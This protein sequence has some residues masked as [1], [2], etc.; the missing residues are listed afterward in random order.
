[1]AVK[2]SAKLT[3]AR[4]ASIPLAYSIKTLLSSACWSC[5]ANIFCR[6]SCSASTCG[7]EM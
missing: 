3:P 1:M 2:A 4:S 7:P 5:S 6:R